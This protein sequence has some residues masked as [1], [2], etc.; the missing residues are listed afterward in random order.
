M[1]ILFKNANIV[2]MN[3]HREII[4]GDLLVDGSRIVAVGGVIEQPA[5]QVID[6][7]GDLLIPGLIQTHIHY[8]E[9][10]PMI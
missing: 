6:I 2:T 9:D 7:R 8:F 5:D 4:Q 1:R 10:R 3:A